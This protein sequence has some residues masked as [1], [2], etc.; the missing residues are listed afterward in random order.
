MRIRT[1]VSLPP[2]R[3]SSPFREPGG[4]LPLS[5]PIRIHVGGLLHTQVAPEQPTVLT[6]G[7]QA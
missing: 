6:R 3:Q 1:T 2:Y 4:L 7:R 5:L